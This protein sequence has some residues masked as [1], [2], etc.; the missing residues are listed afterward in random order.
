MDL[1]EISYEIIFIVTVRIHV[2]D[3]R[4]RNANINGQYLFAAVLSCITRRRGFGGYLLYVSY[5]LGL[6]SGAASAGI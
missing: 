4:L 5:V 1:L 3:G 2:L 6:S